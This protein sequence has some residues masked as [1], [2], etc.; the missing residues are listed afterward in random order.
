MKIKLR[1]KI[2]YQGLRSWVIYSALISYFCFINTTCK[3]R[4]L[5]HSIILFV[6]G[7]V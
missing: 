4:I 7:I 3:F 2:V 1:Y 5:S 6:I